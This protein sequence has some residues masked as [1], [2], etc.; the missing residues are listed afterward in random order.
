MTNTIYVGI[1]PGVHGGIAA[2]YPNGA[3]EFQKFATLSKGDVWNLMSYIFDPIR[4]EK[5]PQLKFRVV[6]EKVS[7]YMGKAKGAGD[8]T[9]GSSMFVFGE[10]FGL[11]QGCLLGCGLREGVDYHLVTPQKW[12]AGVGIPSKDSRETRTLWKRRL[13]LTAEKIFPQLKLTLDVADALLIAHY[14]R[15]TYKE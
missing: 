1:D 11:V 10:N 6:L 15:Q 4:D 13:K 3:I 7:G 9:P 8:D 2:I 12:Q 14:C 5:A